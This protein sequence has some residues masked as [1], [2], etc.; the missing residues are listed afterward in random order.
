LEELSLTENLLSVI[1]NL[2]KRLK[3]LHVNANRYISLT[4]LKELPN[5]SKSREL[6]H[7]GFSYNFI[8]SIKKEC[9]YNTIVSLDFSWNLLLDL[10]NTIESLSCLPNLKLLCLFGNPLF[11]VT[12]YRSRVKNGLKSLKVLDE[13][14]LDAE[15]TD[16]QESTVNSSNVSL[17]FH[18]KR[19]KGLSDPPPASQS[20]DKPPEE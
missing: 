6:I 19:L 8:E 17:Q 4:R 14:S 10:E 9:F 1:N 2:P 7:V 15:V 18:L 20:N 3:I 5:L 16:N 13:I 12:N 11:L